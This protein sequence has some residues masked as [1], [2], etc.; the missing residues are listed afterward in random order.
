GERQIAQELVV[1]ASLGDDADVADL[2]VAGYHV[3]R[4]ELLEPAEHLDPAA[5]VH[6]RVLGREVRVDRKDPRLDQ[7]AREEN[8]ILR[9][10]GDLVAARVCEAAVQELD[11]AT[12]EIELGPVAVVGLVRLDE[13]DTL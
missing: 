4:S 8:P 1:L 10:P 6:V 13:L 9:E 2:A 11:G 7:V 5:A 3:A 12:A